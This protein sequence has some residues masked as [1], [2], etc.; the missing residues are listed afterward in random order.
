MRARW[1]VRASPAVEEDTVIVEGGE[2]AP[3]ADAE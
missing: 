1:R 3:A 2:H